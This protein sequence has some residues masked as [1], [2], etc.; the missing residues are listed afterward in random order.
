MSQC[1]CVTSSWHHASHC[2]CQTH[3][4]V[5]IYR[6]LLCMADVT[7]L[8]CVVH[9][10]SVFTYIIL[11]IYWCA[12]ICVCVVCVFFC[13]LA[14]KVAIWVSGWE[15][16]PHHLHTHAINTVTHTSSRTINSV[17]SGLFLSSVQPGLNLKPIKEEKNEDS[18]MWD[19]FNVTKSWHE[20]WKWKHAAM[21]IGFL[22]STH[23]GVVIIGGTNSL[24]E[25]SFNVS[26]VDYRA[27]YSTCRHTFVLW[28]NVCGHTIM[29]MVQW[30]LSMWFCCTQVTLNE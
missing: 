16:L 18:L 7:K 14:C 30:Q 12:S 10:V 1:V 19:S 17:I 23:V 29:Y 22:D 24:R 9:N 13:L 28:P 25:A 5:C 4:C 27:G 2:L 3:V 8:V 21:G 26:Q 6:N 15:D 11:Y 20:W